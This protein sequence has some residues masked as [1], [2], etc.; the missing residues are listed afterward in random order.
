MTTTV[1]DGVAE[2]EVA[3]VDV[4]HWA[5]ERPW[6][7]QAAAVISMALDGTVDV[8]VS[9]RCTDPWTIGSMQP[10]GRSR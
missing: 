3:L 5:S 8:R 10:A 4:A 1:F 7:V 6:C 9:Y 2:L